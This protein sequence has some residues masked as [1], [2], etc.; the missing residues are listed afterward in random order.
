MVRRAQRG[1]TLI[2]LLVVMGIIA[3]LT[4]L[5]VPMAQ[6]ARAAGHDVSCKGNLREL[7][8]AL[9]LYMDSHDDFIPRRGQGV[10]K[11]GVI[12]RMSDWFNCLP[13]YAG[14]PS[15]FELVTQGRR[16]GEGDRTV[17]TCPVARDPG[18]LYFL[19]YGM[20][21][22]LSPWIRPAPHRITEIPIPSRT[23]FLADGEGFYSATVP[24]CK[25]YSVVARHLG[26]ANLAF[27]DNHVGGFDGAYL[28]CGA[29]DPGRPDVL[30]QTGSGGVNQSPVP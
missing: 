6:R 27:L 23:V 1:F 7:G 25:G 29:G 24:S 30:W 15:Y 28:G 10:Q 9:A 3:A 16:P 2:E 13:Y 19:S 8:H 4:A 12:N 11:L 5:L 21:M 18:W 14:E 26:K 17:F 22:Y 20:N